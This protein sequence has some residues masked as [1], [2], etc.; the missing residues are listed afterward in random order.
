[1]LTGEF[2]LIYKVEDK[3]N[4]NY[5]KAMMGQFRR[6]IDDL[7]L[8]EIPLHGRKLTWSNQQESHTLVKLDRVLCTIDWEELYLNC[9]LQ[10]MATNDSDHPPP[11]LG[12]KDN[13]SDGSHFHF[14]AF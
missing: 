8:K 5:N 10:S 2:N 4:S 14:E 6:F 13:Q 7:A 1:M 9:L 12:L 11:Y 3:T